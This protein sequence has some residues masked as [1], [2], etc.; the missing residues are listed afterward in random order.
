[1]IGVT[2]G[3]D[4]NQRSVRHCCGLAAMALCLLAA[5]A[6]AEP[7]PGVVAFTV[8]KVTKRFFDTHMPAFFERNIP[9]T[10][11]GQTQPIPGAPGDITLDDVRSLADHGWEFGAQGFTQT[12]LT[13]ATDD[14]LEMELGV[15]AAQIHVQAGTFPVTFAWP[16]NDRVLDRV[17]LYDKAHFRGWGNE[18]INLFDQADPFL[19]YREHVSN[20]KSVADICA[21]MERAGREGYWLVYI[22][23]RIIDVPTDEHENA[24]EQFHGVLDCADRLRDAGV[25]RL[26]TARNALEIVPDTPKGH[27]AERLF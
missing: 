1:M 18:G 23:H 10:M 26:M 17:R 7:A 6:V 22:W 21:E 25:I 3:H 5:N 13:K 2:A 16:N 8:D 20:A 4:G 14:M 9:G 24:G 11:F 27:R 15:P 19:I 12:P